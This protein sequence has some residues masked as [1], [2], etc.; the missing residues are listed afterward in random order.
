MISTGKITHAN[1]NPSNIHIS[2]INVLIVL[3]IIIQKIFAWFANGKYR[4]YGKSSNDNDDPSNHRIS[5][6]RRTSY[7][8]LNPY[9][10]CDKTQHIKSYDTEAYY[11]DL[12]WI[13]NT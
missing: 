1:D 9:I 4:W 2:N 8:A 10:F 12:F 11:K 3:Y 5:N 13:Y 7:F 6:N